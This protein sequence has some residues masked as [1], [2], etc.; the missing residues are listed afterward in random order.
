MIE[1][2][3]LRLWLIQWV[4]KHKYVSEKMKS[5]TQTVLP[6]PIAKL[7]TSSCTVLVSAALSLSTGGARG[8]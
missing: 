3:K 6:P 1:T 4:K 2:P 7:V 8:A 5:W